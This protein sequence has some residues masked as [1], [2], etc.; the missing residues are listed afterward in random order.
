MVLAGVVMMLR[1]VPKVTELPQSG[2][3]RMLLLKLGLVGL[4]LVAAQ[5]CPQL[6]GTTSRQDS[7]RLR[8]LLMA[9]GVELVPGGRDPHLDLRAG[10]PGAAQ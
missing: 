6:H 8:P 5:Q 10:R 4:L 2:Y 9:V 7:T 1:V 3:G